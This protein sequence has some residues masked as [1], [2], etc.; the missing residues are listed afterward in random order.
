MDDLTKQVEESQFR[1]LNILDEIKY[2]NS[3][4]SKL[5]NKNSTK[6]VKRVYKMG[7]DHW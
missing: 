7:G 2:F 5:L 4:I 3:R 1:I 6:T